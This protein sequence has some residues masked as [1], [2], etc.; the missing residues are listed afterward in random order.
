MTLPWASSQPRDAGGKLWCR[1]GTRLARAVGDGPAGSGVAPEGE[2]VLRHGLGLVWMVAIAQDH[3]G[4]AVW[5]EPVP[6]QA[7]ALEPMAGRQHARVGAVPSPTICVE[8]L[9]AD[10]VLG[11]GRCG[12]VDRR[13]ELH[14]AEFA[15]GDGVEQLVWEPGRRR[16]QP[17]VVRA[18]PVDAREQ[19]R[20][21]RRGVDRGARGRVAQDAQQRELFGRGAPA[22]VLTG[23][24]SKSR[25]PEPQPRRARSERPARGT[26]CGAGRD[27]RGAIGASQTRTSSTSKRSMNVDMV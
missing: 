19:R 21:Q 13:V 14:P 12:G 2:G 6:V 20:A 22:A 23:C 5:H 17:Y 15:A 1:P 4:D 10:Q 8:T 7:G 9:D 18:N 26:S 24:P 25:S 11:F 3:A 27:G 16:Q